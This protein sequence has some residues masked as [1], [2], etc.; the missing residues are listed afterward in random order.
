MSIWR[1]SQPIALISRSAWSSV[2]VLVAKPGIVTPRM[3][4]RGRPSGSIAR[5]HTSSAWVES[6][7]PETPIT[8]FL[9]PLAD[10]RCVRPCTWML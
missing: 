4:V 8:S 5:A 6:S 7:P 2:R 9:M 10:N 3:L 1:E